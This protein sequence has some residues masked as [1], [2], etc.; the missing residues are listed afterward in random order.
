MST[1]NYPTKEVLKNAIHTAYL[2][3]DKEFDG[4][5]NT[6]KTFVWKRLIGH[7]QKSLRINWVG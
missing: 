7:Q 5:E 6:Q 2:S 4:I 3:L 1:L